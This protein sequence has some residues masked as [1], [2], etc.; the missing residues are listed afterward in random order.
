MSLHPAKGLTKIIILTC[1]ILFGLSISV[2]HAENPPFD[3]NKLYFESIKTPASNWGLLEDRE[4]FIWVTTASESFRY[5]GNSF[6]PYEELP[7]YSSSV[8]EDHQGILWF[9][10]VSTLVSYDKASDTTR[11][12]KAD[13]A[14]VK[15]LPGGFSIDGSQYFAEDSR[16]NLWLATTKGLCRYDRE[17]QSFVTVR[18][19]GDAS[20]MD[21]QVSA[22]LPSADGQLWVGTRS[23][24]H[25]FDP[26]TGRVTKWYK[27]DNFTANALHGEFVL[28][29]WEEEN[30]VLWVGTKTGCL[31]RLDPATDSFSHYM[32][33]PD[34]SHGGSHSHVRTLFVSPDTPDL[35]W[36]GT[37]GGGLNI[38]NRVSGEFHEYRYDENSLGQGS[39][40]DND[41]LKI[42]QDRRNKN[43][44]VLSRNSLNRIDPGAQPFT[45]HVT[46]SGNPNS[47]LPGAHYIGI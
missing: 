9:S 21:N 45:A 47:L 13:P 27:S 1:L 15:A 17:Q 20:P 31:S 38:L 23:G 28:A 7:I 41:I 34:E 10:T 40:G 42:I 29:L 8:Y 35:L 3:L 39:I 30:G 37:F 11:T 16:G 44:W 2:I 12:F 25:K 32:H 33:D 19:V 4:G 5:D 22:L 46:K 6:K 36:I 26:F 14:D 18:T 43:I 24:L